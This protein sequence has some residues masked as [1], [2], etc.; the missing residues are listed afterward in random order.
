MRRVDL[1]ITA[2]PRPRWFYL[3]CSAGIA[4][5]L[6][7]APTAAL[8]AFTC[9]ASTPGLAFGG[10]N[11]YSAAV[12]NGNGTISV[13]CTL[14]PPANDG[15]VSYTLSLSAGGGSFVQRQMAAGAYTLNYNLYTSNAYAVVWGDGTGNTQIESGTMQLNKTT[16]PSQTNMHTVYGQIPALQDAGVSPSYRDNVTVTVSF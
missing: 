9:S 14:I 8:A 1:V 16:N 15:K 12:T 4:L 10:Y 13:T 2:W 7:L 3:A 6:G 11:V 5:G